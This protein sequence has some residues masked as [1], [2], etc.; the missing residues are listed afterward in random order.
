MQ[1]KDRA[2]LV[3]KRCGLLLIAGI[4]YVL[5]IRIFHLGI[6]CPFWRISGYKCPGC[7][8]SRMCLALL[9]LDFREAFLQNQV[10]FVL[11]PFLLT[12]IGRVN[13][14]YIRSGDA[15]CTKSENLMIYAM[16]VILLV[17][18]FVRNQLS[19]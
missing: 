1:R 19:L 8:V 6:S 3:L 12:I 4:L 17:W 18:G 16:I 9:R 11:A 14:R 15:R 10:L 2:V 5:C 7:G 13:W